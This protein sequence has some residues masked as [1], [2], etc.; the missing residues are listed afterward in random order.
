MFYRESKNAD[1]KTPSCQVYFLGGSGTLYPANSLDKRITNLD[2]IHKI[3]PGRGSDIWFWA[4]AVAKGTKQVCL[5]TPKDLTLFFG[6]PETK[7]T[8]PKDTPGKEVMENRFQMTI[9]FFEIREQ[10]LATLPDKS[11]IDSENK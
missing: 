7:K 4:A 1:Y 11:A 10:L 5:G 8:K 9:D 3:V 6:I 2:A